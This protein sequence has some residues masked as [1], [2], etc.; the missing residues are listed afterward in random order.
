[1]LPKQKKSDASPK[2]PP[3]KWSQVWF[4][5]PPLAAPPPPRAAGA[6][7]GGRETG[8]G[9]PP[10][11]RA[12]GVRAPD[13]R[14]RTPPLPPLAS[15]CRRKS[16]RKIPL[17][18][19]LLGAARARG[20]PGRRAPPARQTPKRTAR[21]TGKPGRKAPPARQTPNHAA[22]AIKKA[23]CSENFSGRVTHPAPAPLVGRK[24]A[25]KG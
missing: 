19:I 7:T 12:V 11:P 5:A 24:A 17:R 13:S 20:K 25:G 4:G 22:R 8:G 23:D 6:E 10:P 2:N 9:E 18:K 21:A 3:K 15:E 14:L 16:D 1:M